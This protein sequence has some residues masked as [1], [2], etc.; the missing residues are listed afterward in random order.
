M[1]SPENGGGVR[2]SVSIGNSSLIGMC[3]GGED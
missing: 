3:G 1:G 2:L